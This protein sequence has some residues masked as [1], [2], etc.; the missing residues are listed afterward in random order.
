MP[1]LRPISAETA[2]NLRK[3]LAAHNEA[4]VDW[5]GT[6][7]KCGT[8]R[9]GALKDLRTPCPVCGHGQ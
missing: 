6:C 3:S 5:R 1:N 9:V 4:Q 7:Q 2:V 8:T